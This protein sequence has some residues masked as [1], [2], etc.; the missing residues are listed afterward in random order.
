LAKVSNEVKVALTIIAAIIVAFFGFRTMRDLPLFRQSQVLY[1]YFERVDGLT[2]GNYIYINGVKV[3]SVSQISLI[4][5]DSV[6]VALNFNLGVEIPEGSVA[7]LESSGLFDEKAV[8]IQRGEGEENIEYGG[9]IKGVYRGGI[10][11]SIKNEGEKLS[12]DVSQ[13]FNKLNTLL[14]RLNNTLTENNQAKIDDILSDLRNTTGEVD[15]LMQQKSRDLETSI[16]HAARFFANL[17]T[18]STNN[19][20][21]V[22]SALVAMNRSLQRIE[23]LSGEL[24]QTST[25]LNE[26]LTKINSGEGSLGKLVNDP[27]LYNNM[28]SLTVELKTLIENINKNPRKYLKHMRLIEVF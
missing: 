19:K 28:D 3:G 12:D 27:S 8:I 13:S 16:E 21:R 17:D 2:A 10:M 5:D 25:M 23:Q 9:T 26:I 22:D 20:G 24:E 15:R 7:Y 11:D 1:S 6:R 18:V 4:D 14:E